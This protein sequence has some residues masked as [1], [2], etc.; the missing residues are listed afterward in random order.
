MFLFSCFQDF[1][2]AKSFSWGHS[3]PHVLWG[4]R[5][6]DK[7]MIYDRRV[8]K[9]V[10][11]CREEQQS[12][13]I[14]EDKLRQLARRLIM[15]C[16]MV[17]VLEV[18]SCGVTSFGDPARDH[19]LLK[20]ATICLTSLSLSLSLSLSYLSLSLSLS[21]FNY[22]VPPGQTEIRLFLC[23]VHWKY[24]PIWA[25]SSF[26]CIYKKAPLCC[27]YWFCIIGNN[28][29]LVKEKTSGPQIF[30]FKWF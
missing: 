3:S 27:F 24:G 19:D 6:I 7:C 9:T 30:N 4:H 29:Y 28:L 14:S 21:F 13:G 15:I 5:Q 26:M 10:S 1:A 11:V 25:S 23:V 22:E 12:S 2:A 18:K 16:W 17:I 8:S 20:T